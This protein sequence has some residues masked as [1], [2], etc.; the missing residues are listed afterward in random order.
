LGLRWQESQ[1]SPLGSRNIVLGRRSSTQ[2]SHS[3]I[4]FAE[5]LQAGLNVTAPALFVLGVGSLLH[6]LA[7]R[8][9]IPILYGLVLW[10]FVIQ[11]IGS[12]ITTNHWLLDTAVLSHLGPVPVTSLDWTAIAWLT[13]L[14]VIATTRRDPRVLAASLGSAAVMGLIVANSGGSA[15]SS[16]AGPSAL[17]AGHGARRRRGRHVAGSNATV[18]LS[19]FSWT[20]C[21]EVAATRVRT[22]RRR[23]Q[24]GSRARRRCP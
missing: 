5:M 11:I 24:R 15:G 20:G 2:L 17:S 16:D 18:N 23:T 14:G 12:S 21:C 9:A 6:G 4:G 8:P 10:S 22:A 13:G 1:A 3:D 7:P 19:G